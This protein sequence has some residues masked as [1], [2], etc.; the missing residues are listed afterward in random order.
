M[1]IIK[2]GLAPLSF[3]GPDPDSDCYENFRNRAG[4]LGCLN[5]GSLL[6]NSQ[7][8]NKMVGK[9]NGLTV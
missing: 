6:G 5:Y 3:R 9:R 1:I 2:Q 4:L 8:E 7:K